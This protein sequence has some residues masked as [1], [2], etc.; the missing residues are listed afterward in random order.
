MA[1]TLT[2]TA[3]INGVLIDVD[4]AVLEDQIE[5][6]GVRRTDNLDVVVASGTALTRISLGT[7]QHEFA[8]PEPNLSYEYTVKIT[9]GGTSYYFNRITA[10]VGVSA[11]IAI[12]STDHYSSQ[13]EVLR[14]A[15]EYA[16]D[17]ML[18]D[19]DGEDM[20][21][22][23]HNFLQDA[24]ETIAMYVMQHYDPDDLYSTEW[25]RRRATWMVC[26]LLSQRRGNNDLFRSKVERIYDELN[27]IRDGRM[28]IP[29]ATVRHW[30]G[31]NWRNYSLENRY[32]RHPVRVDR[33]KSNKQTYSGQD[34]SAAPYF[35]LY[36]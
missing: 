7:Y 4:A 15:G 6:F 35:Y 5:D 17:L 24:D 8:E 33:T 21:Y 25:I 36:G 18:D 12:P 23:W 27:M 9:Y 26:N 14:V 11:L 28:R 34:D 32:L 31:P 20:G 3:K 29:G 2:F 13:A 16:I 19:Y 1:V 22:I 30:M 10:A